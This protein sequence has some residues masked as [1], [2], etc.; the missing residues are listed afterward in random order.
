VLVKAEVASKI[1][2]EVWRVEVV[3]ITGVLV[4]KAVVSNAGASNVCFV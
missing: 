4:V 2:V 1:G 3:S